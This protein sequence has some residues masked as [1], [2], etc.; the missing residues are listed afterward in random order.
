MTSGAEF[1]RSSEVEH[2]VLGST[3]VGC[4]SALWSSFVSAVS[5]SFQCVGPTGCAPHPSALGVRPGAPRTEAG[6]ERVG[7]IPGRRF[8]GLAGHHLHLLS[9]A[10]ARP[11]DGIPRGGRET[12]SQACGSVQLLLNTSALSALG[13]PGHRGEGEHQDCSAPS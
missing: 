3:G 8:R 2:R 5:L 13:S 9:A 10:T 4:F 6:R 7:R 1:G 12:T 11:P